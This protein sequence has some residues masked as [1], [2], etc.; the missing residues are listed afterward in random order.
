MD[1]ACIGKKC[2]RGTCG[3]LKLN[4]PMVSAWFILRGTMEVYSLT[5]QIKIKTLS[6][7]RSCQ[8]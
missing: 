3:S 6:S 1:S 2:M 8:A 5:E 4:I 7:G